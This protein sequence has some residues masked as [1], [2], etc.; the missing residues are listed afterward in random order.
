[1]PVGS[2]DADLQ[3][4]L[5]LKNGEEAAFR[6]L[7]ARFQPPLLAFAA[8]FVPDP[9]SAAELVQDTFVKVWTNRQT[10]N[11]DGALSAYLYKI[12]RN[13][14]LNHLR[15]RASEGALRREWAR[16]RSP[17]V[18]S[19][20]VALHTAQLASLVETVVS[21]LP[22]QRQRI[23]RLSREEGLSY[24]EIAAQ[25]NLSRSTV[26][27]QLVQAL[28]ALRQHLRVHT[29]VTLLLLGWLAAG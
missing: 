4:I 19:P 11:P 1:M 26:R 6:Q 24:D 8:R 7:Y 13:A 28:L 25:L 22:P 20:E 10:L 29:D 21:G 3:W 9:D 5:R 18:P 16:L 23:Y 2:Q 15:Q 14:L 27:G 12:T 17:A